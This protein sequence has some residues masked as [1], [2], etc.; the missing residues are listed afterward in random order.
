MRVTRRRQMIVGLVMLP[1]RVLVVL[2]YP[3]MMF[4]CLFGQW[5]SPAL[6]LG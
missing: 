6:D 2:R 3:L 5:T 1:R 4:H